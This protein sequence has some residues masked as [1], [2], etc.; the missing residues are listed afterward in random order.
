MAVNRTLQIDEE[1][2][3][4]VLDLLADDVDY[5]DV[6]EG[7]DLDPPPTEAEIIEAYDKVS[8]HMKAAYLNKR[9]EFYGY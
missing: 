7:L 5:L 3:C 2:Q 8:A 6:A 9:R 4:I 1:V